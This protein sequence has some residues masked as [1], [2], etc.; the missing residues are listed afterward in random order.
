MLV[1]V[2]TALVMTPLILGGVYLGLYVGGQLGYWRLVLPI[3]FST[4]GFIA[5]MAI[6]FRVIKAVVARTDRT[7]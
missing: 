3:A 6:I 1:V 5:G 2:V 7:S 4:A